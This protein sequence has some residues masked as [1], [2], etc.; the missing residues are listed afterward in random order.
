MRCLNQMSHLIICHG[1]IFNYDCTVWLSSWYLYFVDIY[2]APFQRR[3]LIAINWFSLDKDDKAGKCD[4]DTLSNY[5]LAKKS[6]MKNE[7]WDFIRQLQSNIKREKLI[8]IN[9]LYLYFNCLLD[10]ND[11][12]LTPGPTPITNQFWKWQYVYIY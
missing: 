9:Y 12:S 3:K 2:R 5:K 11:S 4:E 1:L 6:T 10:T 8:S 7:Q